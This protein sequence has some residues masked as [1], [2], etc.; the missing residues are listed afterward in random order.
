[1][2]LVCETENRRLWS[3][4]L[5][6]NRSLHSS[7]FK[8]AFPCLIYS[9]QETD[10]AF[11][12]MVAS[13]IMGSGCQFVVCGGVECE[14]WH[15]VIDNSIMVAEMIGEHD[16]HKTI[17]TTWH[18]GDGSD[19][20][21]FFFIHTTFLPEEDSQPSFFEMASMDYL[22]LFVGHS[23]DSAILE[24]CLCNYLKQE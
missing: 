20:L 16:P 7:L 18:A 15:D 24:A 3:A 1:M 23:P 13:E 21:A 8:E 5:F 10:L 11:K 14:Q 19:E 22:V 4:D 6:D 9:S 2:T 17:M 12:T